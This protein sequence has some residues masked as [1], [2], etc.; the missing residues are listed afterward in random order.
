MEPIRE[1][2]EDKILLLW[3]VG[4]C[5]SWRSWSGFAVYLREAGAEG[6]P[7]IGA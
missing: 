4:W 7:G 1:G 5:Q 3:A 6:S 2:V